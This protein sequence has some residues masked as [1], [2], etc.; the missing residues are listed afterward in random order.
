MGGRGDCCIWF[1]LI[2]MDIMKLN[3]KPSTNKTTNTLT[4]TRARMHG[5]N[6]FIREA[7]VDG[8]H[9]AGTNP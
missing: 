6:S 8:S 9:P 7:F 5:A 1:G 4:G 3:G 2:M